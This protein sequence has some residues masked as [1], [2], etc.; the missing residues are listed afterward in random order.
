MKI[1]LPFV[2]MFILVGCIAIDS[3]RNSIDLD[4]NDQVSIVDFIDSVSIVLLET[5]EKSLISDLS[6]IIPYNNRYYILDIRLQAVFCFEHSGKF[7]FKIDQRGRGPEEYSY[8]EDFNI[9]PYNNQIMLLV[10]FGEILYFN[11]DGLFLSKVSLPSETKAYSEVYALNPDELLF[12][13]LSEYQAVYYS[14]KT[15][16]IINEFFPNQIP[17]FFLATE[18]S[19]TFNRNIYFNSILTNKVINMSDSKQEV[20]YYWDFGKKNNTSKQI[21]IFHDFLKQQEK[22]RS[23]SLYMKDLI[24]EGKKLN[25]FIYS[26][27]ETNRYRIALLEYKGSIHTVIVDK[28]NLKNYV[29]TETIEG[30]QFF[31]RNLHDE[32]VFLYETGIGQTFYAKNILSQKQIKMIETHKN[33]DDNPFLVIYKLKK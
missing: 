25:Y 1:V 27:Y 11:L 15:N 33:D 28:N 22:N 21:A 17:S 9:D 30:I 10:P 19:F 29:F 8:I 13:S 2:G 12:I 24:G 32:S 18:R 31:F 3:K 7:L 20:A 26:S 4:Q 6:K 16:T 5:N 14:R 23:K